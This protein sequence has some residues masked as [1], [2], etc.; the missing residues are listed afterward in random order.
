M[1]CAN[2]DKKFWKNAFIIVGR[3]SNT[4]ILLGKWFVFVNALIQNV[5]RVRIMRKTVI[6]TNFQFLI[7]PSIFDSSYRGG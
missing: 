1:R 3:D 5:H 6:H 2:F 7:S 4:T